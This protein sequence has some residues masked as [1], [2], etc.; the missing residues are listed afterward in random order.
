MAHCGSSSNMIQYD[1]TSNENSTTYRMLQL[2]QDDDGQSRIV[3]SACNTPMSVQNVNGTLSTIGMQTS[4]VIGQSTTGGQFLVMMSPNEANQLP[5]QQR[6]LVPRPPNCTVTSSGVTG[7]SRDD[8][9]KIIHKEVERRRRDK[10]NTWIEMLAKLIPDCTDD[11][12]LNESKCAVLSKACDY[13]TS[14]N[15]ANESLAASETDYVTA[16]EQMNDLR[17]QLAMLQEENRLLWSELT[18]RGIPVP[19]SQLQLRSTIVLDD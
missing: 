11:V 8:R 7:S 16:S 17:R 6:Q 1:G 18:Q 13:I 5:A 4:R 15:D 10:I 3:D 19:S 9:R 2:I 12:K 14:L